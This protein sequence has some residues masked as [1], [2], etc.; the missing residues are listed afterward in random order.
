LRLVNCKQLNDLKTNINHIYNRGFNMRLIETMAPQGP[1]PQKGFSLIE[2]M[3]VLA[4]AALLVI[5][6]LWSKQIVDDSLN[7]NQFTADIATLAT[8]AR[9][10]R[11]LAP[12]YTGI[13]VTALTGMGLLPTSWGAGSGVNPAG[14]DYTLAV[15]T[16]DSTR[17]DLTA[18]GMS[19]VACLNVEKK[20]EGSTDG[21][22]SA[23]C[24][25]GTLTA[26]FR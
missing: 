16:S 2:I 1:Q 13:S 23:T 7:S 5:G 17:V 12:T 3:A 9:A 22:S 4:I 25:S 14:G 10:Y 15:N 18:T 8:Q 20:I 26:V 19:Q 11:G 21:G 6:V 24:S